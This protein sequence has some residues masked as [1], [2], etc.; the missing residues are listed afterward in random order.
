MKFCRAII[1]TATL[2]ILISGLV[3]QHNPSKERGDPNW[4]ANTKL[5]GNNIRT[6]IFNFGQTGRTGAVPI[7]VET[8]YEWPKNTG[9]VYLALTGL[10]FGGEITDEN[11]QKQRI[12]SVMNYRENPNTR[13]TWNFEPVPGYHNFDSESPANSVDPKTW[14]AFWPDKL[15]DENDPGWAGSWN[16]YFGK[17][18][19][20]A[21]QEIYY[22]A[23]DDNYDRYN[24]FPDTTDLTRKG[25]GLILDVRN[26]AWSQVLVSDVVYLIHS[27]KNDGTKDIEKFAMTLW[28]ADFVGGDGDSQDDITD[29]DLLEDIIWSHDNDHKAPTFGSDPVGIVGV[30][31]LETPGIAVDRIDN[32]GD[33]ERNGPIVTEEMLVGE[34]QTNLMDDNGNGLIDENMTHVPF[35]TQAGV[36][37]ADFIDN[38]LNGEENS[39]LVTQEMIN[40]SASDQ[41]QRWPVNPENDPIQNGQVHLLMLDDEDIGKGFKDNIDN[42]DNAEEGSPVISQEMINAAATDAPYYRYIVPGTDIILYDLKAEDLGKAY[43]DGIDNDGDKAVD[44]GIDEDIDEMIDERRDDGVDNDGD[45]NPFLSDVGLDGLADTGDQG[46]GDGLPTSG[47]GTPFPGEPGIDKT[48]V[49]ETDQIG[50]TNAFR[51]SAGA[52]NINS[53][54]V[55][56][57]DMMIPGKFYD[58]QE[59]VAGEFDVTISSA[60]FPLRAGQEEPVSLAVILANGPAT[61]PNASVRK[62]SVL[63]KRIR[64][65]ETYNNDYQFANAPITPTLRAVPGNNRVTL[66]WDDLAESSFDAFINNIGGEGFDFEGYRIYRASDPALE[67]IKNITNAFGEPVFSTP[68]AQFDIVNSYGITQENPLGLDSTGID[69]A[70][71]FLGYNTGLRHSFIDSS[72]KNGFTY[73]YVLTSYD[74]GYPMG[75]ILPTESPYKINIMGDGSVDLSKNVVRVIPAA[76]AAGYVPA[77]LGEPELVQGTTTGKVF[78]EIVD[79]DSLRNGH[80]Y[81]ITFEDTLIVGTGGKPDILTTKNFSLTD[82]TAAETL[83]EKSPNFDSN[84]EHP[85][86]HGFRLSFINE[87][88]VGLNVAKSGWNNKKIF[89]FE[90]QKFV[91]S[92]G[93]KG[94]ERP[95]DYKIIFGEVGVGRSSEFKVGNNTF[96]AKDVNFQVYNISSAQFM[97]FGF[98][99]LDTEQGGEGVLSF[100]AS[101]ISRKDRIV[102]LEPDNEGELI[103]TWWFFLNPVKD[104]TVN[105]LPAAGDEVLLEISKPFLRN[106]IFR[107]EAQSA[108]IEKNQAQKDLE[109]IKVVPNPYRGF[110][111]FEVKSIYDS[112]R[113]PRLL[114]FTHLPNKCTIRIFTI[115]G[116]LVDTIE[117]ESALNDGTAYWDML[118]KD[119]LAISYGIYIYHVEAPGIGEKVGK[120]AIIK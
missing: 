62:Q 101:N 23:S 16:G 85:L 37:F 48:D 76:P 91:A 65:Q 27:I 36:S 88:K 8:P 109:N 72:A 38:D 24:Y 68:L 13:Q 33:G 105:R 69:G 28:V 49:A 50:I 5:E 115:N 93:I 15:T 75:N 84:Y 104:D 86:V 119:N 32:D 18:K 103:Y 34:D 78:Y 35:G 71:F 113:A 6:S 64:A 43:V 59:V 22:R 19:F 116:E 17:N 12:I 94:E 45:W 87:E 51:F 57:F 60:Y 40:F 81:K 96:P 120:F 3:A 98:I 108:Y 112:G 63:K 26:M 47:A 90:F 97:D 39:P 1:I 117:H 95:N 83:I 66:Y 25:L 77:T 21:D 56:W 58:P 46:E 67:D 31:I 53:D 99:E 100:V 82:S 102:F 74:R 89:P 7:S 41:W 14:P 114:Q 9:K 111:K 29:F 106:D 42:N 52:L 118:S 80:V 70:N 73:Y 30:T 4:R 107:L 54:A 2:S 79:P 11:G 110:A 20:S 44:E 61:D 10:F 55:M 92:G